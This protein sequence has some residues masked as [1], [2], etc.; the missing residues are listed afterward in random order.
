M[1]ATLSIAVLFGTLAVVAPASAAA[2]LSAR[3]ATVD[4][5]TATPTNP[6]DDS[7]ATILRNEPPLQCLEVRGASTKP[8]AVVQVARCTGK[9][10]Q[11]WSYRRG[12]SIRALGA[13]CLTV[14]GGKTA[15][16]TRVRMQPCNGSVGQKWSRLRAPH[17]PFVL[18]NP[19]SG[20]CLS[21]LNLYPKPGTPVML[22]GCDSHTFG[23]MWSD[24]FE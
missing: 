11:M 12:S 4:A 5:A 6:P 10:Q 19:H 20:L 16:G 23:R 9:K 8:G 18:K 22:D 17:H 24:S 15:V 13:N 1:K 7:P 21:P 14:D 2:P 3:P